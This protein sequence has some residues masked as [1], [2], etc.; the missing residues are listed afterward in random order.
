VTSTEP[1]P[2]SAQPPTSS[3]AQQREV[4]A[5]PKRGSETAWDMI[6]SIGLILVVVAV[7]LIFVPGLLH[8]TKSDKFPA[9]D[10]SS[11]VSGF[12]QV[13]GHAALVPSP[14][15]S[16]WKANAGTLNGPKATERFHV[17]F[18]VPGTQYAGLDESVGPMSMLVSTV[19]G[20]R[21]LTV[22]GSTHIDGAV[23]T[24]RLSARGEPA[25]TRTVNGVNVVVT[26]SATGVQLEQLVGALQ[27]ATS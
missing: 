11:Y 19:L 17:G 8:P 4:V 2:T 20:K 26:G 1:S 7:T 27:P 9:V 23:W 22:T 21:G 10:Y 24:T 3:P 12:R 6:R 16:G 13:T 18:A 25:L 15:P 14:Q 5:K